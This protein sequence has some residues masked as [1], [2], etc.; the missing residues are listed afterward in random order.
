MH[1]LM[2]KSFFLKVYFYFMYMSKYFC[3]CVSVHHMHV[4]TTR[5]EEG[6]GPPGDGV[7]AA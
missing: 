4:A 6:L 1:L 3:V 2:L 5:P 7:P